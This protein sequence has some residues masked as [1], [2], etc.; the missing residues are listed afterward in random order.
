[1]LFS[2]KDEENSEEPAK[3]T[4]E[5]DNKKD[6]PE[7]ESNMSPE[8]KDPAST[9][10]SKSDPKEDSESSDTEADSKLSMAEMKSRLTQLQ[11]ENS[12]L[13]TTIGENQKNIR[14]ACLGQD[15]FR[16]RYWILPNAG[17]VFAEGGQT[18]EFRALREIVKRKFLE[19]AVAVKGEIKKEVT[20]T[21]ME[22]DEE[23]VKVRIFQVTG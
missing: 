20:E 21:K 7:S 11:L 16:R 2:G 19:D 17:G 12:N 3:F 8:K 14:S 15:R 6:G 4:P 1:L 18:A 5:E 23:I 9:G 13:K 22:V 10:K